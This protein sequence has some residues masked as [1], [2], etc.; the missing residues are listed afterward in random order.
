MSCSLSVDFLEPCATA[1]SR[2]AAGGMN[3]SQ[4]NHTGIRRIIQVLDNPGKNDDAAHHG[5]F[6]PDEVPSVA[7][8]FSQTL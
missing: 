2:R 8:L 5:C 1:A 4:K 7:L 6:A 3:M